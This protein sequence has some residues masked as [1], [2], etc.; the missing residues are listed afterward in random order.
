MLLK[1]LIGVALAA[2]KWIESLRLG[3]RARPHVAE[4]YDRLTN[5]ATHV[6]AFVGGFGRRC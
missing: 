4:A 5:A 3:D 1:V 2:A 6:S